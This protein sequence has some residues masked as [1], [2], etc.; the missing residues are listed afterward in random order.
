MHLAYLF[1]KWKESLNT[2]SN[3]YKLLD[4]IEPHQPF[5]VESNYAHDEE[6][7]L[8]HR[9]LHCSCQGEFAEE[10][11][12]DNALPI[13]PQKGAALNDN[14]ILQ[15]IGPTWT[16]TSLVDE[17]NV[18]FTLSMAVMMT[19]APEDLSL[20]LE[21]LLVQLPQNQVCL[22]P[23]SLASTEILPQHPCLL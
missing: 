4:S 13:M 3:F 18:L 9:A 7:F 6:K 5:Q 14:N 16:D 15:D 20:E 10:L 23:A 12:V 21:T 1:D 8:T 2:Q 19:H 17:I 22:C 11:S